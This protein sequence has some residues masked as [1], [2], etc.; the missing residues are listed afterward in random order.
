LIIKDTHLLIVQIATYPQIYLSKSTHF[1]HAMKI[2]IHEFKSSNYNK[3][4]IRRTKEYTMLTFYY[5][6]SII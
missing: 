3:Y 5:Y 1:H 2:G 6:T 4:N